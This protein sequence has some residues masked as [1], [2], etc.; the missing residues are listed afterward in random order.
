MGESRYPYLIL[1]YCWGQTNDKAKT[2]KTKIVER[3]KHIAVSMLPKTI[4]DAIRLTRA[5]GYSYLWVDAL[6]IKQ[7]D[8][9]H[10]GEWE[11]EA[12]KVGDYY[13]NADCLISAAGYRDSREGFLS[14][15]PVWKYPN[16]RSLVTHG[17]S[18]CGTKYVYVWAKM[19]EQDFSNDFAATPI[20]SR[21]W[22][23]QER[24]LCPRRLHWT[25]NGLF[26]E[27]NTVVT[28]E[29]QALRGDYPFEVLPDSQQTEMG[30]IY[31]EASQSVTIGETWMSLVNDYITMKLTVESD[32]LAAIHGIAT[33]LADL[34]NDE[35][36][37]GIFRSQLARGLAWRIRDCDAI[38]KGTP[39][40][41]FPTWS[42]AYPLQ[43]P[44]RIDSVYATPHLASTSIV[45]LVSFPKSPSLT[46]FGG[47][48]TRELIIKAPLLEVIVSFPIVDWLSHTNGPVKVSGQP[49]GQ[50]KV[51]PSDGLLCYDRD[52]LDLL[53]Q[54]L[55]EPI[56]MTVAFLQYTNS[57]PTLLIGLCLKQ[58][59]KG[60]PRYEREGYIE[61]TLDTHREWIKDI[62]ASEI[63]IV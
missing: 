24:V 33:R 23:F 11:V 28:S 8:K 5:M 44:K 53:E 26:W 16:R 50:E 43:Y 29:Q 18:S 57:S 39:S 2:T 19:P 3:H 38:L 42:W 27:C 49:E 48:S 56:T 51:P 34:H 30:S 46:D 35:Y 6:C 9:G 32:R 21:G 25:R 61:F 31:H 40:L 20:K 13:A 1:S 60:R 37:A 45:E 62:S 52:M 55:P 12:H 47:I 59:S 63:T 54:V 15:G 17:T 7:S 36:C 58:L 10:T 41:N 14:E 22:Y 4:R